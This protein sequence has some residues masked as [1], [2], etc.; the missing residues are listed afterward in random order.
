VR[1]ANRPPAAGSAGAIEIQ[2]AFGDYLLVPKP[3]ESQVQ[4]NRFRNTEISDYRAITRAIGISLI[5]HLEIVPR[6]R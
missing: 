5:S 1:C 4:S 3:R 6:E 2:V